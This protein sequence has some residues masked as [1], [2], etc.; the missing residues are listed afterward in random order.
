MAKSIRWWRWRERRRILAILALESGQR[1]VV[2]VDCKHHRFRIADSRPRRHVCYHPRCLPKVSEEYVFDSID[3]RLIQVTPL[4][5]YK[6]RI[7]SE[8]RDA[9]LLCASGALFEARPWW[10]K[11]RAIIGP[12]LAIDDVAFPIIVILGILAI[13]TGIW[14]VVMLL[15]W[16]WQ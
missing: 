13:A 14:G 15:Q 10:H 1:S 7:C 5:K 16:W 4:D 9:K 3:G 12:Y 6:P 11:L 2:C 8:V